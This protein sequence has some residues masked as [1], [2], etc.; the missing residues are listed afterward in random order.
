[1]HFAQ[2]TRKTYVVRWIVLLLHESFPKMESSAFKT[3][4]KIYFLPVGV[5]LEESPI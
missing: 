4:F 3:Q 1:M 2:L 5:H